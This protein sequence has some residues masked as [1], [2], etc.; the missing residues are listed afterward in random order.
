MTPVEAVAR[1]V[2]EPAAPG[3]SSR[4]VEPCALV[5]FGGTGDLARRKLVPA[6]YDQ[7]REGALPRG[8]SVLGVAR[9]PLS[10]EAFRALH[11]ETTG[12]FSRTG[13]D[14]AAWKRFAASL[15]YLALDPGDAASVGS[16]G[17][18]LARAERERGTSGNRLYYLSTPP[19]AAPGILDALLASGLLR[20]GG[21]ARPWARVVL[22]KPFGRDLA[23]ASEL[24]TKIQ[25]A[26]DESQVFRIDHF[27]GKETVQNIVVFRFGNEIFEPLW[28]R[29]HV[30]HVEVTAAEEI[31]IEGRAS[32]YEDTGV[33]RDIV[34]N[35]LL[36][37][38]ALCAMEPP[39]STAAD[40]LRD[41]TALVLRS[42]R[43]FGPEDV[44]RRL[45]L[46]QYRGY[47][48]E[49]EVARDSRTPTYAALQVFVDNWR[50]QGV[51]FYL[52][53]GKR[54]AKRVTEI[55]VHFR[56]IP[57]C[58]FGEQ[59]CRFERNV[60][61]LRIQPDEGVTLRFA[62]KPP[63]DELVARSVTM[64]FSYAS[65]FDAPVHDAY[66]RL[67]LDAMRGDATLFWRSDAVLRAWE[68]VTPILE[69]TE[70]RGVDVVRPYEPGTA[71]P[72]EADA[73]L[74]RAGHCW[75]PLR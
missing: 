13:L 56:P 65:G 17:E 66:E 45:V 54:L 48:D 60:L 3:R 55:A 16:L 42:L 36:Q 53:T 34:Q 43:P 9:R 1:V 33:L 15:D 32:F 4:A 21:R 26:L 7:F 59:A 35:H 63:G 47:R 39:V 37:V 19:G 11:R 24:D 75:R 64:D 74:A 68:L 44:E 22:E 52:R 25:S 41:Q 57:L 50:W 30:E 29:Q 10:P 6:L 20:R 23:S 70:K 40:D 8:T 14:E 73:L 18:W 71:G 69:A 46:G 5:M 2:P 61:V 67:I 51:P 28:N 27:L 58:L 38:L 62:C 12:R 49:P 31:G 72:P